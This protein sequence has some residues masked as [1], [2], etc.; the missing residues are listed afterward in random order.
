MPNDSLPNA[1]SEDAQWARADTAP[2]LPTASDADA[3]SLPNAPAAPALTPGMTATYPGGQVVT[4]PADLIAAIQ[5]RELVGIALV[6]STR[7]SP[8]TRLDELTLR[9]RDDDRITVRVLRVVLSTLEGLTA[10]DADA[11]NEPCLLDLVDSIGPAPFG[12]EIIY[13]DDPS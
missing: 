4:I 8:V 7:S 9:T 12:V 5:A 6:R 3:A 11:C 1:G 10:A 13:F 2:S